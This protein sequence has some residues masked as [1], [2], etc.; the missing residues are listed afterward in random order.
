MTLIRW[1]IVLVLIMHGIG[2]I[3][4][5]L[6]AWTTIPVGWRDAPWLLGGGYRITSPVGATWGLLW[7]V[8][9]I[10]FVGAG[11]GLIWGQSWWL[12]LATASAVVSLVAILPWWTSAPLGARVG[13]IV[14][15][16][17]VLWLASPLG[18]R[19]L[20]KLNIVT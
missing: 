1:L 13:A 7:L 20:E 15:D 8:T 16:L 2:H 5:F 9:L 11:L 10:G 6:A 3:M 18:A 19:M 17:I 4:G 14:V 12:P